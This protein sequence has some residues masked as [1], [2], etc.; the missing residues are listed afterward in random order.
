MSSEKE[1]YEKVTEVIQAFKVSERM[2]RD[3]KRLAKLH[4]RKITDQARELIDLGLTYLEKQ[5]QGAF[6]ERRELDELIEEKLA[7]YGIAEIGNKDGPTKEKRRAND[8]Q[9]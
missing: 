4:H 3:I 5:S 8:R 6:V 9:H 1:N 2:H 7:K